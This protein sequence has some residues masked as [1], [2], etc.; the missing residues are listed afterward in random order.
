MLL[1]VSYCTPD[2]VQ[3]NVECLNGR[4]EEV[5]CFLRRR[6]GFSAHA[7]DCAVTAVYCEAMPYITGEKFCDIENRRAWVFKVAIR[8]A[9]RAAMREPRVRIV[10][11]A[12]LENNAGDLAGEDDLFDLRGLL[13]QL[14]EQQRDAVERCWLN[15][16][17]QRVAAEKMGIAA[18]TLG[19]RLKAAKNRLEKILSP[20]MS[21]V[22]KKL[23]F[24][25]G[26][27]AS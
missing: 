26:A 6:R 2:E 7:I 11:P 25:P 4:V 8:A 12:I 27:R 23:V 22:G 13:M 14:T 3:R 17:S 9:K 10:E 19:Q 20:H 16:E 15:G 21:R 5:R 18:S 1:P 24:V